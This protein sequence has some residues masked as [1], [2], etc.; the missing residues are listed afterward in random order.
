MLCKGT[1]LEMCG[2]RGNDKKTTKFRGCDAL[3]RKQTRALGNT[4]RLNQLIDNKNE[5][6][7]RTQATTNKQKTTVSLSHIHEKKI[8]TSGRVKWS[9]ALSDIPTRPTTTTECGRRT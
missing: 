9:G 2:G 5:T 1:P 3:A 6:D 7:I 4:Q 8:T